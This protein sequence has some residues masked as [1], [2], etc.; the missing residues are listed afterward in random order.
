MGNKKVVI[1]LDSFRLGGAERQAVLLAEGLIAIYKAPVK[2]I[3]L[4]GEGV[5]S[6]LLAER[7]I[8]W[9][10]LR[11]H[12]RQHLNNRHWRFWL[13][14]FKVA[15][16]LRK[17][18]AHSIVPFTYYPNIVVNLLGK[19]SG[20]KRYFWNQRDGGIFFSGQ[21]LEKIALRKAD[22]FISN[23]IAG[24]EYLTEKQN[25]TP[26]KLAVI[27]NGV[28]LEEPIISTEEWRSSLA[29]SKSHFIVVMIANLHQNKDHATLLQAWKIF[30]TNTSGLPSTPILLLAGRKDGTYNTLRQLT[31][32]LEINSSVQF[33]GTV[34]DIAGLLAVSNVGVFSSCQE[35][36]P[37]GILECM[38][39]GLP[40][41][42]TDITGS[43]EAL[44][45]E[46]PFLSPLGNAQKIADHLFTLYQS[47]KL[48]QAIGYKNYQR[49]KA[50]FAPRV[51]IDQYAK[52]LKL[53]LDTQC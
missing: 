9:R 48:R 34:D 43:R 10:N 26:Q 53:T 44:G 40:V 5:V 46:Y 19:V 33:L 22:S 45:S 38:A 23:S 4:N 2:V 18:Q 8:P 50:N 12:A 15:I 51:M 7:N 27:H 36:C 30:L 49:A 52:L 20:A 16:Q 41:V 37:N 24:M 11:T 35:G 13:A 17:E 39:A 47:T 42:A 25:I 14:L 32:T 29:I 3:A 31:Y 6:R 21:Q 28:Q 1:L